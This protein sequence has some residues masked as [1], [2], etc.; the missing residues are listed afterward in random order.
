MQTRDSLLLLAIIFIVTILGAYT[1][2]V[3]NPKQKIQIKAIFLT[4]IIT[5]IIL[6]G[7]SA[8]LLKILGDTQRFIAFCAVGSL[9]S[10][11]FI[12]WLSTLNVFKR[13]TQAGMKKYNIEEETNMKRRNNDKDDDDNEPPKMT[14]HC[15]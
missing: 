5:T 12:K 8:D 2:D 15:H 7:A 14:P 10:Y 4:S 6:W 9:G 1:A 11:S 13:V 3:L